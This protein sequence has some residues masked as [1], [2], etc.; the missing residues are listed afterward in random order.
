MRIDQP[1]PGDPA[2]PTRGPALRRSGR[3]RPKPRPTRAVTAKRDARK[4]QKPRPRA[5]P[6]ARP[7]A[8]PRPRPSR[9]RGHPSAGRTRS[10]RTCGTGKP[11]ASRCRPLPT[12][13]PGP[14]RCRSCGPPGKITR[15]G[16][17]SGRGPRRRRHQMAAGPPAITAGST[18]SR[19]PRRPRRTPT[20][21]TKP[22]GTS[23]PPC[24]ASRRP[25]R[26][27]S[28]QALSTWSRAKTASKRSS[29]MAGVVDQDSA[30]RQVL[31]MIP[32]AVRF[33]LTY[34]S[35]RYADGVIA[36]IDRLKA[37]GFELIKLKNLW[38]ADQ[39]KGV[40]S[41]WRSPEIGTR[42]EMQFHTPESLEAKELTHA[43]LRAHPV[44]CGAASRRTRPRRGARPGE[45]PAARER[46]GRHS[47][48]N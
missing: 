48:W 40:N 18:P 7:T 25:T 16:I 3:K 33:T 28:W 24:A 29:R 32:D 36:D 47:P 42:F 13:P 1:E 31:N 46:T 17:Q 11:S 30:L 4:R 21:P 26:T 8:A 27:G 19:T 10:P 15:T 14:R 35:E 9:R 20:W 38:H 39:Y 37:E 23:C 45:L 22:A 43:G 34:S 2:R 41:Q 12:A 6:G 5:R 44:K